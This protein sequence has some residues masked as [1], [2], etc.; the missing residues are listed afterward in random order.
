MYWMSFIFVFTFGL[1]W[2]D[3]TIIDL[4]RVYEAEGWSCVW[5][6]LDFGD[7]DHVWH[8]FV[9]HARII[10]HIQPHTTGPKSQANLQE[11]QDRFY[12]LLLA[13]VLILSFSHGWG[14]RSDATGGIRT[15]I[16]I[17]N[18]LKVL[19]GSRAF[20][21]SLFGLH[22]HHCITLTSSVLGHGWSMPGPAYFCFLSSGYLDEC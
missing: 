1:C 16:Q 2:L 11:E 9:L 22:I 10:G 5:C 6:I 4:R 8:C 21:H 18:A 3:T 19:V 12:D 13:A 7:E 15:V 20:I 17:A 14:L